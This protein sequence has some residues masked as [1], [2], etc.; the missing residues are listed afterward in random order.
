MQ[1]TVFAKKKSTK[2]GKIFYTY[3]TT[4]TKKDGTEEMIEVKFREDC[5]A[6][7]AENCPMNVICDKADANISKKMITREDTG[8]LYECKTLWI[9]AWSE[10]DAYID[11]SLDEYEL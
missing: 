2:E 5:G 8:E 11:T 4:L 10:G 3:L 6:P 7:K 1:I 9:S